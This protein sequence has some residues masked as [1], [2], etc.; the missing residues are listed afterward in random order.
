MKNSIKFKFFPFH[1]RSHLTKTAGWLP[2][3]ENWGPNIEEPYGWEKAIT[4]SSGN[5]QIYYIK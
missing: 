3:T 2:P 1:F 4:N 5:G